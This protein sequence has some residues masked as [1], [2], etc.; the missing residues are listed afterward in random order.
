MNYQ[1]VWDIEGTPQA[2]FEMGFELFTQWF[3]DEIGTDTL[4][5][6][7]LKTL[8]SQLQDGAILEHTIKGNTLTM[9]LNHDEIEITADSLEADIPDEMPEGTEIS[10]DGCVSGCGLADFVSVLDS[11]EAFVLGQ[12]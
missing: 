9:I 2:E 5:I 12:G 11:W 10:D 3:C 1:F 7:A 8:I 4:K 6:N